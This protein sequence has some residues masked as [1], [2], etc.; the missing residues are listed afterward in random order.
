MAITCAV[1]CGKRK[2]TVIEFTTVVLM[3]EIVKRGEAENIDLAGRKLKL[4]DLIGYRDKSVVS[5]TL[6]DEETGSI[7]LFAFDA[8]HGLSEHAAPFDALVHILDGEAEVVIS[9]KPVHLRVGESIIMPA[10]KPHTL[11][12]IKK[13]KMLLVMIRS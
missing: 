5:R 2:D 3:S 11:K 12:A 6:V 8:G 13:F 1:I 9:E 10:N 4:V 7:T